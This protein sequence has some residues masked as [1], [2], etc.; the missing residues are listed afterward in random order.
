MS[1]KAAASLYPTLS[2]YRQ[3]LRAH[4]KLPEAQRELGDAYVKAEFRLHRGASATFA[5]QFE[6]QW[7]DYLTVLSRPEDDGTVGRV[8]TPEEVA[9][10]SDEQKVQLLKIREETAGPPI[11]ETR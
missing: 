11:V 4:R 1:R 9:A 2:L 5:L 8:M 3:I 7:R 10:L 6:R